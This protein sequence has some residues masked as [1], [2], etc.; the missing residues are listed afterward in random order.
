MSKKSLIQKKPVKIDLSGIKLAV[1]LKDSA[2]WYSGAYL[3]LAIFHRLQAQCK[4][5]LEKMALSVYVVVGA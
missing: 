4:K 1:D 3:K 2:A 5:T